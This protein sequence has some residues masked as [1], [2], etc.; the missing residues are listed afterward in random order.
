MNYLKTLL[1]SQRAM[2]MVISVV[3]G[4]LSKYGFDVDA[5]T[6]NAFAQGLLELVSVASGLYAAGRHVVQKKKAK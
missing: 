2:A 3:S 1:T 4:V 6:Q 5:E